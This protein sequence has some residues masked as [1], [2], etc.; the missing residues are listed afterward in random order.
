METLPTPASLSAEL[1]APIIHDPHDAP[2]R[3]IALSDA[4]ARDLVQLFKLLADETRL[5]IM[6]YLMQISEMNVR[7]FVGLLGQT[8]PAVSHHLAML[9]EAG[10]IECRR[11]GKHNFYHL[12]RTR[13]EALLQI[14]F[15]SA[16]VSAAGDRPSIAAVTVQR[17]GQ[18]PY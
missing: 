12:V 3:L 18:T 14:A 7:T 4:A 16:V 6:H 13:C 9:R 5:R 2:A 17:E 11:S 8:Q 15:S 1:T 10:M